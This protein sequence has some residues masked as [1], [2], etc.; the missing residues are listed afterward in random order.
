M[1][2]NIE[3]ELVDLG[4]IDLSNIIEIY[5]TVR[6]SNNIRVLKDKL[7]NVIYLSENNYID[8]SKY[9]EKK[10]VDYWGGVNYVKQ[11]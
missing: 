8:N 6:D 5:P 2:N 9:E 3:N 1:Q 7:S 4:I 11:L 10:F